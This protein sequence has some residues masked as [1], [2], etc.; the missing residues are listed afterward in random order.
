MDGRTLRLLIVDDDEAW[1][2]LLK[3]TFQGREDIYLAEAV[4]G[5]DAVEKIKASD[6]DL[7]LLD[8]RMPAST[9]GLDVLVQ[10]KP[11][12]P[13]MQ[14]IMMS[15]YG[16]IRTAVEAIKRGALDF[17]PK[18]A[19]F[20]DL[21][22]FKVNEVIRT[23]HLI[24]DR[25]LLIQAKYEEVRRGGDA[26]TKGKALED[27][28]AA[29]F[30]SV[31]GFVVIGCNRHTETE[32]ID[33]VIRNES[34]DPVWQKEDSLIL[35]ECKNWGSQRVG[36][37]EFVLFREK[38]ENRRGRCTLGFLVCTVT[39]A[40]TVTKEMLRSSH[41]ELLVV[42]IDGNDLRQLVESIDRKRLL[43]GFVERAALI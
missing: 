9:E 40:E 41:S 19:D 13:H 39:F 35:V 5:P 32:E 29:L 15:A 17:V 7:V 20:K 27:L 23:T 8:M 42:P 25:E 14:V 21:I 37:N 11:L 26:R 12:R 16:D 31:E 22:T 4:S 24:A 34:R 2:E 18:E 28:V 6:F 36:K 3:F 1:R 43:R 10:I 33:L 38:L 30:A